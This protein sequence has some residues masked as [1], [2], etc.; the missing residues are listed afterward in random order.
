[1]KLDNGYVYSDNGIVFTADNIVIEDVSR[2]MGKTIGEADI[3]KKVTLPISHYIDA[4]VVVISTYEGNGFFHWMFDVL[5]RINII[6]KSGYD[7]DYILVNDIHFKFQEETLRLLGVLDK[8]ITLSPNKCIQANKL[9]VPSFPGNTGNMPKWACEFLYMLFTPF[10][11]VT[12]SNKKRLYISRSKTNRRRVLNETEVIS[13]LEPLGFEVVFSEEITF[14]EQINLFCNA[15]V[16]V[17]PHGAGLSNLVFCQK[18]TRILELFSPN[19]VNV[20]YYAL[21]NMMELDYYYLIGDGKRPPEFYDP[22]LD[23][24][25]MIIN[26]GSLKEILNKMGL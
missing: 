22:L 9:L 14:K 2:P 18:K 4:T 5:P 15:E 3:F 12:N 19:Y 26:V 24:E 13:I 11:E 1:M 23:T 17:A 10:C 7:F 6:K 8:I 16:I 20:C 21:S 25:D